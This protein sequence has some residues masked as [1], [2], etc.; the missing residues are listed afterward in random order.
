MRIYYSIHNKYESVIFYLDLFLFSEIM[1]EDEEEETTSL[2][3]SGRG[4]PSE[5]S[6]RQMEY[7]HQMFEEQIKRKGKIN[8]K[9]VK[10]EIG[11]V[12]CLRPQQPWPPYP[13]SWP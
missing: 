11:R 8:G 10:E 12:K 2:L 1:S 7:I 4:K 3:S 6:E 13:A 9:I 5:F